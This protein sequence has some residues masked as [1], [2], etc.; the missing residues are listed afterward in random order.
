M[1]I[2]KIM[3]EHIHIS[4]QDKVTAALDNLSKSETLVELCTA[5]SFNSCSRII[6]RNVD[7]EIMG[8]I[9]DLP[10]ALLD[11][12]DFC[13]WL[14]KFCRI[15]YR[16]PTSVQQDIALELYNDLCGIA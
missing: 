4:I 9:V 6:T 15:D 1:S 3:S 8:V 2:K 5:N 14:N 16:Q 7:G 11:D 12:N 13:E 10:D